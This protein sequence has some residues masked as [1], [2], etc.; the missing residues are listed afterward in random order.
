MKTPV[1][2]AYVGLATRFIAPAFSQTAPKDLVG[3]R[4]FVSITLEYD[5][6]KMHFFKANPQDQVT[7]NPNG[8]FPS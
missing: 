4:T 6:K 3:T 7:F 8:R 2:L 1:L 5:G